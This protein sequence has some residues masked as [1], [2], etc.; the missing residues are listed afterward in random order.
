MKKRKF[1]LLNAI[2]LSRVFFKC[3]QNKSVEEVELNIS[4]YK[5]KLG[6]KK[7]RKLKE[8]EQMSLMFK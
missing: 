3:N 5:Q 6:I 2:I 1:P 7:E 4:F 8:D